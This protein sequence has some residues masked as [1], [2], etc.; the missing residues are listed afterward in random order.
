ML[1][2]L[3]LLLIYAISTAVRIGTCFD[4]NAT[5]L[6]KALLNNTMC[7]YSRFSSIVCLLPQ[8]QLSNLHNNTRGVLS[9][10][11]PIAASENSNSDEC[12]TSHS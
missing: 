12:L 3:F 1:G 5:R 11:F 10:V 9:N 4:L 8:P 2:N 6:P 7:F